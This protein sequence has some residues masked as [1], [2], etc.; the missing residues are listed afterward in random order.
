MTYRH[1]PHWKPSLVILLLLMLLLLPVQGGAE[2]PSSLQVRFHAFPNGLGLYHV[3]KDWTSIKLSATVWVGGADEDPR[4]NAGVSHL[5]E[6]ILFH[7]PDMPVKEFM[8]RINLRAGTYNGVTA[9]DYTQYDVSLPSGFLELGQEWLSKVLFHDRLVT[10]RL[11]QEKEIVNR[12]E[13]WSRPTPWHR[14]WNFIHPKYLKLPDNWEHQ[15][16]LPEYDDRVTYEVA[17]QLTPAQ[18]EAHYRRYYYP[19]NIVLVY[20]GP[21]DLKEV[22]TL[23]GPTFGSVPAT[24][25][26]P[27]FSRP[28]DI[29]LLP[30]YF[31][32]KISGLIATKHGFAWDSSY[33]IR[34][35]RVF[36][37]LRL[38]DLPK[39]TRYQP[40]LEK[41]L[42]DR[43][44]H[45]A[46]ETYS[47]SSLL[48]HHRGVGVLLFDLEAG[49]DTYWTH[50]KHV[51]ELVWGDLAAHFS[52]SD[53]Q[54]S[55][56]ERYYRGSA[57]SVHERIWS[58]IYSH[59]LHRPAPEEAD[60]DGQGVSYE[61]LLE[62]A[63]TWRGR[64]APLL[65]LSMPAVPFPYAHLLA[66]ALSMGLGVHLARCL[67][68]R[69]YPRE[70]LRLITRVP[71]GILGWV[72]LG[73]F[74]LVAAFVYFHL[75]WGVSYVQQFFSRADTLALL[76][77]YLNQI[78]NGL[79]IGLCL[80]LAG[81]IM[82]RKVLVTDGALV[83][84]MRSP[85]FFRIPLRDIQ[86]VEP[87]SGWS[88]FRE[89]VRLRALPAYP[90]FLR[91]L[92]IRRRSG[93]A[94]ALHT[95][96]DGE[97][98]ELLQPRREWQQIE[99]EGSTVW[100]SQVAGDGEHT[101]AI[102]GEDPEEALRPR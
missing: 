60:F 87:V 13:K 47:V 23:L 64:T 1:P 86:S 5:L 99:P 81:L 34:I 83:V 58:A 14:L 48:V 61:E 45:E 76:A 88:A 7:Q 30:P 77:P 72:Q 59:P 79:L 80:V 21:H 24:G 36:T 50:L 93:L 41:L 42:L 101:V 100:A 8:D 12:E 102:R 35:G 74:Y 67:V 40:V 19:E 90:W 55:V 31:A 75:S 17:N 56:L 95:R 91:G 38:E 85:L 82:P 37:G 54:K 39:L 73:L 25:R 11:D 43:V 49:P 16:G 15:F 27:N 18:L 44:R 26:K 3:K 66:F 96:D 22:I 57:G 78:L 10:D 52:K 89:I 63:R 71:Y 94:L 51:Q 2:A 98:L 92:L 97:I 9:G 33:K 29:E 32:H 84:K 46:G 6:H 65:E 68:R 4:K 70:N 28:L 20:V 62:W 69:R 53:Y